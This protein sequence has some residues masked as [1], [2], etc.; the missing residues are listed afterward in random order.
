MSFK[1]GTDWQGEREGLWQPSPCLLVG[2][3][4]V[5]SL[6]KNNPGVNIPTLSAAILRLNSGRTHIMFQSRCYLATRVPVN[7]TFQTSWIL[8]HLKTSSKTHSKCA[9]HFRQAEYCLIWK[10][11]ARHIA[12]LHGISDELNTT[13]SENT[14]QHTQQICTAFQTS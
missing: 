4:T 9:R 3:S 11:R 2:G 13:L 5:S 10:H 1:V 12:N 14:E 8:T 7:C 6:W